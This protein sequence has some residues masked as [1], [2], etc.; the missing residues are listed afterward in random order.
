[1][2]GT[3]TTAPVREPRCTCCDLP[4]STCGR[5]AEARIAAADRAERDRLLTQPG[6]R[7]AKFRTTC[8]TCHETID[9]GEPISPATD[10]LWQHAHHDH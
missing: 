2:T 8:P 7:P 10:G 3:P 6:V 1:M 5:A 9:A 4:Q